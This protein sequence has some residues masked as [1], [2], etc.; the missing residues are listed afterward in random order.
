MSP[1]SRS[2]FVVATGGALVA[3]AAAFALVLL[4]SDQFTDGGFLDT[5]TFISV[6][7]WLFLAASVLV[8]GGWTWFLARRFAARDITRWHAA[9]PFL[10]WNAG[11]L[12]A[13]VLATVFDADFGDLRTDPP[14]P[15][16]AADETAQAR[17]QARFERILAHREINEI[18]GMLML[19]MCAAAALLAMVWSVR[20]LG[21]DARKIADDFD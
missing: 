14:I 12:I 21:P 2:R 15:L 1:I 16:E 17:S 13:A 20:A 3:G 7:L 5:S 11:L 8:I 9:I 19:G 6:P 10:M 18:G 4:L